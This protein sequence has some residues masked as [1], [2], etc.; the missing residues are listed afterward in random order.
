MEIPNIYKYKLL[1]TNSD[2]RH[3]FNIVKIKYI[4]A[5]LRSQLGCQK[6][7]IVDATKELQRTKTS[8]VKFFIKIFGGHV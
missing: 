1:R 8:L 2:S 4:V 3:V 6:V 5:F 7:S